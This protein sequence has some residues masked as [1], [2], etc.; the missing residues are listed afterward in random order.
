MK[1]SV[2]IILV[3]VAIVLIAGAYMGYMIYQIS[4]KSEPISGKQDTVPEA[5]SDAPPVTTGEADWTNW[6]G[7]NFEGKSATTGIQTDWSKGL[8]KVWHVNYLCQDKGTAAWSA[9]VVQGNRLIVPGR[10]ETNDLIFCINT[11][12]GELIWKGSYAAEASSSHGPGSRATPFISD[13]KVYTFGRSGDLV[14]WQLQDG[15]MLW[16]KNVKEAGGVEPQWG[17][18]TTPLVQDSMVIVQ[19]GGT[20]LAIAYDKNTGEI[21]WKSMEG[22]AGY[23]AAIPMTVENEVKLL[24]YQATGL[25]CINPADGNHLWTAPW[26]TDYGVNATTP[27]VFNDIVFHTSGYEMGCE[28]LKVTKNGYEVLWKNNLM[29]AQH[30]DPILIDGYL[31][32]YSGES[33]RNDGLFKCIELATG[34]QMWSTDQIGQG[35][36]TYA[37][38]HLVCL[39]IKGNIFLVKPDPSSFVKVGEI[40]TAIEG[41][42]NPA[43]T[44]PVV[45]NG[46]LYLRYLQQLVCYQLKA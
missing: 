17:Y 29:E 44:V 27:I 42:K 7:V 20:A 46:K 31:Y 4:M 3:V 43:W 38:G 2:K 22:D 19:G 18:S 32:G 35:T 12:T 41:V 36:T 6:R 9:P 33:S 10:D 40:K 16:H 11:D 1:K 28:A 23:A 45:A 24:I 26:P 34:K 14:C 13:G 15:Q 39:D 30:S 5:L 21:L 37:D 25:S 8:Q